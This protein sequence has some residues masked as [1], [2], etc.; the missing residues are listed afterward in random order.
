MAIASAVWIRA[1]LNTSWRY[2]A[3]DPTSTS[4]L[5]VLTLLRYEAAGHSLGF[6]VSRSKS[7]L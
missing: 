3:G 5:L 2:E 7:P 1:M 6:S 4:T